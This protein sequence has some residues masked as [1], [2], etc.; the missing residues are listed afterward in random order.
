MA[1]FTW[2]MMASRSQIREQ[3][4]NRWCG[5]ATFL[6]SSPQLWVS[7]FASHDLIQDP[8]Q[9]GKCLASKNWDEHWDEDH[10]GFL[11]ACADGWWSC[12]L[13]GARSIRGQL[14]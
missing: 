10:C 5:W 11:A 2:T 4:A 9:L 7:G 1:Q 6:K 8:Q 14:P 13:A 3:Q 12:A